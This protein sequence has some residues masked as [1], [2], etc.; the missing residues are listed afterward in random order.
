MVLLLLLFSRAFAA[1]RPEDFA[2]GIPIY[3]DV[4]KTLY[5]FD[6][7]P[8]V[9]TGVSRSDLGDIR[10]FNGRGEVVPHAFRPRPATRMEDRPAVTLPV[11][12]LYGEPRDEV[13]ALN[14]RVERRRDGA[15]ISVHDQAKTAAG[16][17]RLRGYLLDASALKEPVQA[18][19]F[20]WRSDSAGFI[21]KVHVEGSDNLSSWSTLNDQAAL[22]HVLFDGH[23]LRRDRVEL[24]TAKYKYLRVSWSESQKPLESLSALAELAAN[25]VSVQ[26]SWQKFSGQA[27]SGKA[28]EYTHDL[29]GS[30]PVDRLRIALP[31]P[32]SVTQM[33]ILSRAKTDQEWRPAARATVYRLRSG[34]AEVTNPDIELNN[35]GERYLL[36]RIDPKGG[37]VGAGVPVIQIGW[38]TQKL[39]FAVRSNGPFQVVY[40]SRTA[41]AAAYPIESLIP[42]YKTDAEFK[43]RPA[44]LG[45]P[46]ILAGPRSL[47]ETIDYKQWTLWS[48]L[49]AAVVLLG[50]MAY[51]L[52]RQVSKSP[53][54][55]DRRKNKN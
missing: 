22:A 21:S 10:I 33:Q 32:N 47:R 17:G 12:P 45:E 46:I 16:V 23:Q 53:E 5:E 49:I 9:Y 4:S 29:S 35:G 26:R 48:I 28:G 54:L 39:V 43:A 27:I 30:F 6:I 38:I 42:G 41:K 40:G 1:E 11:F 7:P 3:A 52:S 37:G 44:S 34:D 36:L 24:R 14:V 8:S 19:R 15:I 2:Y 51:R 18:V 25:A 55:A 31:E 13:N 50:L 20:D